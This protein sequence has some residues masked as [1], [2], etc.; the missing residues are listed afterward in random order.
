[1]LYFN[2]NWIIA[3]IAKFLAQVL[4][5][6][7]DEPQAIEKVF[8]NE[9]VRLRFKTKPHNNKASQLAVQNTTEILVCE[10]HLAVMEVIHYRIENLGTRLLMHRTV[11]SSTIVTV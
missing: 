1:M 9:F 5:Y 7:L 4:S 11:A 6:A 2:I 10:K 8:C 3:K